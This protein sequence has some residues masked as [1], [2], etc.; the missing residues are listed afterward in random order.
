[1]NLGEALKD[2]KNVPFV[3]LNY[4]AKGETYDFV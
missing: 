4:L 1:M 3:V 2:E